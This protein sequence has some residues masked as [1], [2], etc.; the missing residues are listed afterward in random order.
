MALSLQ[1]HF[2]AHYLVELDQ[3]RVVLSRTAVQVWE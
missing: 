1:T 2:A 3:D